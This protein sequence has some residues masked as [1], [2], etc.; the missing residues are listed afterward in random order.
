MTTYVIISS[1]DGHIW[2]V[3]AQDLFRKAPY[4]QRQQGKL[5]Y[6]VDEIEDTWEAANEFMILLKAEDMARRTKKRCVVIAV[7]I[8]LVLIVVAGAGSFGLLV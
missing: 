7:G 5:M 3:T 6:A 4:L 2:Q 8:V 1:K